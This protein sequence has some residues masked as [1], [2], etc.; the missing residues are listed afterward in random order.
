M[1]GGNLLSEVIRYVFVEQLVEGSNTVSVKLPDYLCHPAVGRGT[2]R[3]HLR[4][5]MFALY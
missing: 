5:F 1:S 3:Q 4:A 2:F